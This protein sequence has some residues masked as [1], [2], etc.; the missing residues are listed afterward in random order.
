[1]RRRTNDRRTGKQADRQVD[2]VKDAQTYRPMVSPSFTIQVP[3]RLQLMSSVATSHALHLITM[4]ESVTP[5]VNM[6]ACDRRTIDGYLRATDRL[7]N[8]WE[9]FLH[10]NVELRACE[11]HRC[12]V[13][14]ENSIQESGWKTS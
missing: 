13:A 12:T 6:I 7:D 1:M 4:S 11:S 9:T 14:R 8:A 10:S 3:P 5:C 2:V